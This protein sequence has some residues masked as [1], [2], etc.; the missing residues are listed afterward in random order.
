[1]I[2]S[3][4]LA[5][6]LLRVL[7]WKHNQ[8]ARLE[9]LVRSKDAWYEENSGGFWA[10]WYRDVFDLRTANTFG[11]QVWARILGIRLSLPLDPSNPD[12]PAWAFGSLR[13]NFGRGNFGRVGNGTASLT[14]EEQRLILRLRYFQL[15]TRPS[16]VEINHALRTV[17]GPGRAYVLDPLNMEYITYVFTYNPGNR[18]LG[19]LRDFDILPRPSA[20]GVRT[21]VATRPVFGFGAYNRNFGNGTFATTMT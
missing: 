5:A 20:V 10:R 19:L 8:A 12:A 9:S 3:L 7:L 1:M 18:L 2:Q 4:E 21:V 17:F 16:I 14:L 15:V 11:L 13:Q 6:N